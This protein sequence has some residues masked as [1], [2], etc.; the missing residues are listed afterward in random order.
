M[1]STHIGRPSPK[2]PSCRTCFGIYLS[3]KKEIPT[4]LGIRRSGVFSTPSELQRI[5]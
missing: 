5:S 3:N 1:K 2:A 4:C